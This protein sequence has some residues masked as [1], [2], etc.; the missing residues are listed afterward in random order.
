[1]ASRDAFADLPKI[2]IEVPDGDGFVDLVEF[3][4]YPGMARKYAEMAS[5]GAI[6]ACIYVRQAAARYLK[7]LEEAAGGEANYTFSPAWVCDVC[8]F[9]EKLPVPEGDEGVDDDHVG[10]TFVLQPAQMWWLAAIFGFRRDDPEAPRERGTRLVREAYLEV[11]RG[12][13]KSALLAAVGL[14]LFTCEGVKG[15]K[16]FIGAPKEEQAR[17]V[18]DP[19]TAML[20]NSPDLRSHFNLE[21]TKLRIKKANDPG[22]Y[23]RMISSIADRED[24]ANPHFIIMEELHAQDEALFNVMDS[25]MG[26]RPNNLF[27]SIT[28]A[29]NRSS[30]VCWNTRRRAMNVLAGLEEEESFFCAIYTLDADEVKD[31]K[32]RYDP[33]IWPKAN[34]MW[35]ITLFPSAMLDRYRKARMTSPAAM[36][37]FD[38]TRLNL[39]QNAA[40]GLVHPDNW[41]ACKR[42]GIKIADFRKKPAYIGGDLAS[43]RDITAIGAL[44]QDGDRVVA[45][46]RYFIPQG[47]PSFQKE[48]IGPLYEGWVRNGW[49]T[50]TPT[51]V[52][53]YGF[54]EQ[55]IRDWCDVLD[56]EAIVF[57]NFQSNQVLTSLFN[58][59]YPAMEMPT[60]LKT[61]SDPAQ[62]FFALIEAH[63]LVHEGNPVTEWMAMNTVGY[64][65]KRGNLLPQKESPES[66]NKI[67]GITSLVNAN[68][69]RVDAQLDVPRKRKSVYEGRGLLEL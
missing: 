27:L 54:V 14:Y 47:S 62:D 61:I 38:R 42:P 4:D 63:L 44:I 2:K 53:D 3:P 69:V 21:N 36:L 22:A 49:L 52:T 48:H 8:D 11:P 57:D 59:G 45:F 46:N 37:E 25:S 26:K 16:G 51:P 50:V 67:D 34:P 23:I 29:G 66:D 10:E 60:G 33:S 64:L 65:D 55:A 19:M 15:S 28:T 39:W 7:M 68:V 24:G 32:V 56:V 58:D 30:G 9:I 35:G 43:K 18:F 20:V 13:G 41:A 5:S 31:E 1:M 12:N 6:P 40:G 17:Y